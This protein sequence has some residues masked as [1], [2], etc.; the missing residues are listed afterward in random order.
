MNDISKYVQDCIDVLTNDII[1][2]E[3]D[4]KILEKNK[5]SLKAD[6]EYLFQ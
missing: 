5:L 6:N 3:D 2:L 4:L 1:Q